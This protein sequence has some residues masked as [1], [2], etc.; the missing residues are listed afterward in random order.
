[1]SEFTG[2]TKLVAGNTSE[3]LAGTDRDVA[4]A[5][6]T[7]EA[8]VKEVTGASDTEAIEVFLDSENTFD[9]SRAEFNELQDAFLRLVARIEKYNQGAS[10]KI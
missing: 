1:L 7:A 9:V 8:E 4:V 10:H 6:A 5:S 2:S 3:N